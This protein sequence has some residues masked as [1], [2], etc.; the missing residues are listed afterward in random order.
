VLDEL[1]LRRPD[2]QAGY[3]VRLADGQPWTFPAVRVRMYPEEQPDGT[4]KAMIRPW[5]ADKLER[6]LDVLFGLVEADYADIWQARFTIAVSLLRAN[7]DLPPGAIKDL[8]TYVVG[9]AESERMWEKIRAAILGRDP[10]AADPEG[11]DIDPKEPTP[12]TSGSP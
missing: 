12:S 1:A 5:Y 9:D 4:I 2:F 6:E 3:A 7:Y 10:D 8:L 11:E